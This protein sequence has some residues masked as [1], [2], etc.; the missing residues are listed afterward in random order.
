MPTTTAPQETGNS[1]PSEVTF[2]HY[3]YLEAH[4]YPKLSGYLKR[5]RNQFTGE[6]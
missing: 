2:Q 6:K 4:G 3:K 5:I 1:T